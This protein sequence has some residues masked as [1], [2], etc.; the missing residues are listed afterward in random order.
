VERLSPEAETG[1]YRVAQEALGNARKHAGTRG[2]RVQLALGK[3]KVRLE[4]EDRGRGFDPRAVARGGGP[5]ERVG[6]AGM[7]ERVELLGGELSIES[8]PGNGTCVV[9]EVPR[10]GIVENG[11]GG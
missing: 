3:G 6:L 10:Q 2:A 11:Q 7:L 4:V 9:A 1:L 8:S 5:G